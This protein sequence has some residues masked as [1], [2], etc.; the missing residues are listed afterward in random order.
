LPSIELDI[1]VYRLVEELGYKA[2]EVGQMDPALGMAA[3]NKKIARPW[4]SQPMPEVRRH[5]LQPAESVHT[6]HR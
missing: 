2:E 4:G 5:S 6:G 3:L 1:V